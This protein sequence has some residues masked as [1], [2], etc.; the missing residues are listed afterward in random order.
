[1]RSAE[2][3]SRAHVSPPVLPPP[4]PYTGSGG[5]RTHYYSFP[6][7]PTGEPVT[8]RGRVPV[9]YVNGKVKFTGKREK[10]RKTY[11]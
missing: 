6:L 1:L 7:P 9:P 4:P 3:E 2:G 8:G 5:G 11:R 10:N